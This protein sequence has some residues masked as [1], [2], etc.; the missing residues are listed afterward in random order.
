MP[1]VARGVAHPGSPCSHILPFLRKKGRMCVDPFPWPVPLGPRPAYR[2]PARRMP[3]R[4]LVSLRGN[5]KA[6]LFRSSIHPS[7]HPPR[8]STTGRDPRSRHSLCLPA[9]PAPPLSGLGHGLGHLLACPRPFRVRQDHASSPALWPPCD[10]GWTSRGWRTRL[11]AP[12]SVRTGSLARALHRAHPAAAPSRCGAVGCRECGAG[13]ILCWP[14]SGSR[15]GP[16]GV[17]L[18]RCR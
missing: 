1:A 8:S 13:S 7:I 17:G 18:G 10:L 4:C 11:G 2:I 5:D 6:L 3:C 9:R 14:P 15:H 12:L 16:C